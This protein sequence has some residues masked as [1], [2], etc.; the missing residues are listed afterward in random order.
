MAKSAR[1][2]VENLSP[3]N[4]QDLMIFMP[5]R[6]SCTWSE[7]ASFA[8]TCF[9]NSFFC[10]FRLSQIMR[11]A[12]GTVMNTH[13]ASRQSKKASRMQVRVTVIPFAISGGIVLLSRDSM[14]LQSAIIFVVSSER[15]LVLKKFIG[16]FEDAPQSA[17]VSCLTP[18]TR[19]YRFCG[20]RFWRP[21]I[22][23]WPK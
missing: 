19:Q 6:Y 7:A 5:S 13:R 2:K 22:P 12:I 20:N 15:S 14:L 9:S 21:E 1:F 16:S 17:A 11:K 10:W 8:S 3:L 18:Y 23:G 4:P